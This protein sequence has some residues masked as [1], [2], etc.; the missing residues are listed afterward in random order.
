MLQVVTHE[1]GCTICIVCHLFLI[2][3]NMHGMPFLHHLSCIYQPLVHND[4][5]IGKSFNIVYYR[6]QEA[7]APSLDFPVIV[8][9]KSLKTKLRDT[10]WFVWPRSKNPHTL[11]SIE[12]NR[13]KHAK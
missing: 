6:I 4:I 2:C 9:I 10:K 1:D 8:V 5:R 3:A 7:L 11:M 12:I 13:L